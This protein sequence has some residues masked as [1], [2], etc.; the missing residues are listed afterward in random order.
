MAAAAMKVG[1]V[2]LPLLARIQTQTPYRRWGNAARKAPSLRA[3]LYA[4]RAAAA[5]SAST[6]PALCLRDSARLLHHRIIRCPSRYR[7]T[8]PL[9]PY[10]V[11][12]PSVRV[13]LRVDDVLFASV[14]NAAQWEHW[15]FCATA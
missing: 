14:C 2:V 10:A 4:L 12:S 7:A 11:D 13:L 8:L 6:A 5:A 3:C 15:I 9:L 1:R